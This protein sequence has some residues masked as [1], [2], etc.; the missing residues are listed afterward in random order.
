MCYHNILKQPEFCSKKISVSPLVRTKAN[1]TCTDVK[2]INNYHPSGSI[3]KRKKER[4]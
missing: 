4:T 3:S 2:M 1:N